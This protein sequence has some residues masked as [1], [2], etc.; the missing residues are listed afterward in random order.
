MMHVGGEVESE[1]E[2]ISLLP[3]F[4]HNTSLNFRKLLKSI[5]TSGIL[6][7]LQVFLLNDSLI[8][9][10]EL[11]ADEVLVAL[12]TRFVLQGSIQLLGGGRTLLSSV[13]YYIFSKYLQT[14]SYEDNIFTAPFCEGV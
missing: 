2:C 6:E 13:W 12:L 8:L 7:V 14:A 11:N 3:P 1:A 5:I 4:H 9:S 10:K